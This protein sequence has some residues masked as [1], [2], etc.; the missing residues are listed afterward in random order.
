[1]PSSSCPNCGSQVAGS[2]EYCSKCG[3]NVA[4]TA[5]VQKGDVGMDKSINIVVGAPEHRETTAGGAYCQLCGRFRQSAETFKCRGCERILCECH[6]VEAHRMCE[7]CAPPE[8]P[9]SETDKTGPPAIDEQYTET[10][11]DLESEQIFQLNYSFL[12]QYLPLGKDELCRFLLHISSGDEPIAQEAP[13]LTHLCLVLDVSGSMDSSDKYPLLREATRRLIESLDDTA[14][15]T[16]VL[17]SHDPDLV[18]SRSPAG[19]CRRTIEHVL[20]SID[21]SGVMFGHATYLAPGLR[22]AIGETN[23]FRKISPSCVTRIYVLTDGQ[24]HDPQDCLRYSTQLA[25]SQAEVNSYGFG[26]DFELNAIQELTNRCRGGT[27]K[28]ILDTQQILSTFPHIVKVTQNIAATDAKLLL[29]LS[30]DAIPGDVFEYRPR[31]RYLGSDVYGPTRVFKADIGALEMRRIYTFGFELRP[32]ALSDLRHQVAQ[33]TLRYRRYD[34]LFEKTKPIVLQRTDDARRL[35]LIDDH[36]HT[37]FL[38][39]ES[40]RTVDPQTLLTAYEARLRVYLEERRDP[41]IIRVLA[42]AIS[43]LRLRGSL[44]RLSES[45]L[46]SL[47]ADD[48]TKAPDQASEDALL[49]SL[50]LVKPDGTIDRTKLNEIMTGSDDWL[51]RIIQG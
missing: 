39:L 31:R 43:E 16:I 41:N 23:A 6:Y 33:A 18:L 7:D 48:I 30:E 34:R 27:V 12:N 4:R 50:G 19:E 13:V 10:A 28:A 29:E 51:R 21:Q 46:R 1:M 45:E 15:L 35:Q 24:I 5:F 3:A 8:E 49:K 40:L 14:T 38:I 36:V 32:G 47:E 20:D 42:K 26:S 25:E 22:I 9:D 37:V 11:E 17:F 2:A 44:A